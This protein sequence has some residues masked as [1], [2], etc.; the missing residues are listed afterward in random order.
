MEKPLSILMNELR[1]SLVQAVNESRL[2]VVISAQILGEVQ[3][4]CIAE[5][6]KIE[7]AY[8]AELNSKESEEQKDAIQ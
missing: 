8:Y 2:P 6:K 5:I 7:Q 3:Q 4:L 1:S